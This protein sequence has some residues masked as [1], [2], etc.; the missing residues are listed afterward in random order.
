[1]PINGIH[2]NEQTSTL[3]INALS[4]EKAQDNPGVKGT[5]GSGEDDQIKAGPAYALDEPDGYRKP[6]SYDVKK[7]EDGNTKITFGSEAAQAGKPENAFLEKAQ[8]FFDRSDTHP[9]LYSVS[10]DADGKLS[11]E[12]I[13]EIGQSK[14][15]APEKSG[16]KKEIEEKE[17]ANKEEDNCSWMIM[18]LIPDPEDPDNPYKAKRRIVSQGKGRVP[19]VDASKTPQLSHR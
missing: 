8:K 6:Y 19:G 14:E 3:G 17:D 10:E 7:D 13:R 15:A 1:M 2:S 5:V 18:E 11:V 4:A 16:G 9:G 12:E